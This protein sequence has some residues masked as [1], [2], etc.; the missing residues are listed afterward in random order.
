MR[1]VSGVGVVVAEH[2]RVPPDDL[3]TRSMLRMQSLFLVR[4]VVAGSLGAMYSYVRAAICVRAYGAITQLGGVVDQGPRK[5]V[6]R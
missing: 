6:A 5:V 4:C 1:R 2:S 3:V